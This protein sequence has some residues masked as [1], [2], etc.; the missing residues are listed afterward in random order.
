MDG[1]GG[2]SVGGLRVIGGACAEWGRGAR[3][4][5]A[6]GGSVGRSG[7]VVVVMLLVGL[8][9]SSVLRSQ[10]LGLSV[11]EL[12]VG[13][14]AESAGARGVDGAVVLGFLLGVGG[15]W[16]SGRCGAFLL[17]YGP[18]VSCA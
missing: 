18:S 14:V 13:L 9:A 12:G 5:G 11:R 6:A 4:T 7:S 15:W 16:D 17:A 2:G 8:P 10:R 3:V 1:D